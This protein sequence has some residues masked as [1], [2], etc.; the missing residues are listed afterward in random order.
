MPDNPNQNNNGNP[1]NGN[2]PN[3]N[4]LIS[5]TLNTKINHLVNQLQTD[6]SKQAEIIVKKEQKEQSVTYQQTYGNAEDNIDTRNKSPETIAKEIEIFNENKAMYIDI[7]RNEATGKPYHKVRNPN[8]GDLFNA[9]SMEIG[10]LEVDYKNEQLKK[11][12]LATKRIGK[13]IESFTSSSTVNGKIE[14]GIRATDVQHEVLKQ[15]KMSPSELEKQFGQSDL[16]LNAIAS[17]MERLK[18]EEMLTSED[19]IHPEFQERLAAQSVLHGEE[20]NKRTVLQGIQRAQVKLGTDA[21]STTVRRL[22]TSMQAEE[23]L[24]DKSSSQQL[25]KAASDYLESVKKLEAEIDTTSEN[26]KN[27]TEN[28]KYLGD[29][30]NKIVKDG[31]T[32]LGK[33]KKGWDT[34]GV[35]GASISTIGGLISNIGVGNRLHDRANIAGM[36]NLENNRYSTYQAGRAGD[37]AAQLEMMQ[38]DSTSQFA[39][40]IKATSQAGQAVNTFGNAV[41]GAANVAGQIAV[42]NGL[43]ALSAGVQGGTNLIQS[44]ADIGMGITSGQ[45]YIQAINVDTAAKNAI[46][47][48][49]AKQM[50]GLRDFYTGAGSVAQGMGS[51]GGSFL[52][53]FVNNE[54]K[55]GGPKFWDKMKGYQISPEQ[56]L[57]MSDIGNQ[58]MGSTFSTNQVFRSKSLERAGLGSMQQNIERMGILATSGS[59][60]PQSGLESVMAAALTKSLDSSKTLNAMAENTAAMVKE[61]GAAAAGIDTTGIIAAQIASQVDSTSGN[62]EFSLSRAIRSQ[63]AAQQDQTNV[64]TTFSGFLNTSRISKVGSIGGVEALAVGAMTAAELKALEND[65]NAK[66]KLANMGVDIGKQDAST[67]IKSQVRLKQRQTAEMSGVTNAVNK[68]LSEHQLNALLGGDLQEGTTEFREAG[69]AVAGSAGKYKTVKEYQ[70]AVRSG[71]VNAAST[72]GIDDRLKDP[73]NK[74]LATMQNLR[75]GGF[76]QLSESAESAAKQLNAVGGALEIFTTMNERIKKNAEKTESDFFTAA[77]K[78]ATDFQ[79]AAGRFDD[80]VDKFA[81]LMGKNISRTGMNSAKTIED[82]KSMKIGKENLGGIESTWNVE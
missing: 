37:V 75:D 33:D 5:N 52:G 42:G 7:I 66:S 62:K 38:W 48:I 14:R 81:G 2:S 69:L 57:Q 23:A 19:V 51:R 39:S 55:D 30:F 64:S 71:G 11:A 21:A 32:V 20:V 77:S 73:S 31:G 59:N 67:W 16:R 50:Q 46:N 8:L 58:T 34:I 78:A 26:F 13:E 49:P 45:N 41:T 25:K 35:A 12:R 22:K 72:E 18:E 79:V 65:P 56:M 68:G 9:P 28:T 70:N 61:S 29:A 80:A 54:S 27:L 1:P 82:H 4:S 44:G 6:S 3:G 36:A 17:E 10:K 60:N 40:Q 47:A 63:Q 53:E 24:D 76:K 15:V 43:G 74:L